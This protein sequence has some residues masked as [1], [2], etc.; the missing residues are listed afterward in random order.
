MA[1]SAPQL[2]ELARRIVA[3][4]GGGSPD[5]AATTAAVESAC[6]GLKDHLVDLLGSGGVFAL[7]KRA[8]HLAQREQ[9]LLSAVAVSGD[10]DVCFIGLAESLEA[11]TEAEATAAATTILT[12]MLEL[13][14]TLLGEEL[15]M[16]PVHKLWPEATSAR[17]IDQ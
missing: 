16:K 6:R 5:P 8:V 7:L 15:G 4:E 14:V 3:Q 2:A 9:P 11:G 10:A 1:H 17:E 12:H 13:L